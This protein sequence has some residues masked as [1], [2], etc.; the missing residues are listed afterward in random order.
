MPRFF[1]SAR[2]AAYARLTR[3]DKPIG[4]LLLLW[5]TLTALWIAAD[6]VPSAYLIFVFV[7]GT[8]LMRSAG[9]AVNDYA[10]RKFDGHVARTRTRPLVTGEVSG[11][12][13]WALAGVLALCA[14][15]L[16]L[17]INRAVVLWSVP[18][19][20]VAILYP[21]TKRWLAAPQAVL[22]IAFS[23][24]IPMAFAAVRGEVPGQAWVLLVLNW[25]WVMAY[26]T[27]YAMT[28]RADDDKLSIGSSAK[29]FGRFDVVAVMCCYAFY[30]AGMA[31]FGLKSTFGAV[32]YCGLGLA[33]GIAI[34]HYTLIKNREP[35]QCFRA[36]LHN[37]W[38]GFVVFLSTCGHFALR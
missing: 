25:F 12:E 11:K 16:I 10:D 37:H 13:A 9:C 23:F 27:E 2:C 3:I 20:A 7:A 18:A 32:F 14:F 22:G 19:L 17:P 35:L 28:D 21:F 8:F 31:I 26:D 24:G 4:T 36:F 33:A 34:Y 30:L 6:G 29:W 15:V 1:T 5:P 38:L